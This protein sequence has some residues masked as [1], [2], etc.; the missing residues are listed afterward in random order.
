MI[1]F[2]EKIFGPV[3]VIPTFETAEQ[4]IRKVSNS[5]YG[6]SAR[7]SYRTLNEPIDWPENGKRDGMDQ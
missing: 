7:Y 4:A 6:L 1:I 2:R 5:V 3:V